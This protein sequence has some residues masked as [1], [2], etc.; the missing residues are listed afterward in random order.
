MAFPSRS[1]AAWLSEESKNPGTCTVRSWVRSPRLGPQPFAERALC[2]ST[3]LKVRGKDRAF[4]PMAP[5]ALLSQETCSTPSFLNLLQPLDPAAPGAP[6]RFRRAAALP[7]LASPPRSPQERALPPP[8]H[9]AN[10]LSTIPGLRDALRPHVLSCPLRSRCPPPT[11]CDSPSPF[12]LP[13]CSPFPEWPEWV[14]K[15]RYP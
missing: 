5:D 10:T 14:C 12:C 11:C 3:S 9:S 6:F 8:P 1:A 7:V 4:F 15:P 2:G 13:H